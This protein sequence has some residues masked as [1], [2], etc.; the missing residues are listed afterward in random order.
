MMMRPDVLQTYLSNMYDDY[1]T[2]MS[3]K[4]YDKI[5]EWLNRLIE[6]DFDDYDKANIMRT[7]FIIVKSSHLFSDFKMRLSFQEEKCLARL[8][9]KR[10]V[11]KYNYEL[12]K[13]KTDQHS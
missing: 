11:K 1:H 2:M 7:A 12:D 13:A 3:D 6:R 9:H 10:K 8:K 4:D 5:E